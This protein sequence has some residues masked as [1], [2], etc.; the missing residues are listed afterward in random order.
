MHLV[1]RED[2]PREDAAQE[3]A[4]QEDAAQEDAAQDS[5][6]T[7]L[8]SV[9]RE[10]TAR[11]GAVQEGAADADEAAAVGWRQRPRDKRASL[12]ERRVTRGA[13]PRASPTV[14]RASLEDSP[15]GPREN[16]GYLWFS[17]PPPPL[18]PRAPAP[19][20]SVVRAPPTVHRADRQR[21]TSRTCS[22]TPPRPSR[23]AVPR[24]AARA[25]LAESRQRAG[26][27]SL[28]TARAWSVV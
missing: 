17:Y 22:R 8:D 6:S 18:R 7:A 13:R 27:S 5:E 26:L 14:S 23:R 12:A 16:A 1:P 21:H 28:A 9:L 2:A 11:Q 20:T 15:L 3:D 10:S 4:A 24:V 25:R 19:A